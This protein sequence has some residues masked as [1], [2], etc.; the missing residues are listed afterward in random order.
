MEREPR[1]KFCVHGDDRVQIE[2]A[3]PVDDEFHWKR[4]AVASCRD[5]CTLLRLQL[6]WK[7]SSVASCRDQCTSAIAGKLEA[8]SHSELPRP[9][10]VAA[11]AAKLSWKRLAVASCRDQ[12]T[13]AIAATLEAASSS[14]LPRP[15]TLLRH[16]QQRLLQPQREIRSRYNDERQARRR[17]HV[18][19][20]VRTVLLT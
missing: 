9:M 18:E 17:H 13:S 6:S 16:V 15:T 8:A 20:E 5:Q 4:L 2:F 7:R 12:C 10:H 14:E 11:I 19:S 1:F 3:L